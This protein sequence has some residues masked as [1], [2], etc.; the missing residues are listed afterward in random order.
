MRLYLATYTLPNGHRGQLHVMA[1][2][3]YAVLERLWALF[4]ELRGCSVRLAA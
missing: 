1:S 4:G 2:G 3:W